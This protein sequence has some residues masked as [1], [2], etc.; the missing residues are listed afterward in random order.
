MNLS[1]V[2]SLFLLVNFYSS[3]ASNSTYYLIPTREGLAVHLMSLNTIYLQ[4]VKS[5]GRVLVLV[6]FTSD[7]YVDSGW[8]NL[9]DYFLFPDN[10]VCTSEHPV[11]VV[12]RMPCVVD[13]SGVWP[14]HKDEHVFLNP[15]FD[16]ELRSTEFPLISKGTYHMDKD[17]CGLYVSEDASRKAEWFPIKPRERYV[18]FYMLIKK[19]FQ[20]LSGA[21]PN[22]VIKYT[23]LHWRRGDQL[24]E[25]CKNG[26]D[27]SINCMNSTNVLS[28]VQ[29]M[30]L[31]DKSITS[32][33]YI[34]TNEGNTTML[35]ELEKAGIY[36]WW[37]LYKNYKFKMKSIEMFIIELQL[38][39]DA[40]RFLRTRA[41]F[42]WMSF[43]SWVDQLIEIERERL[44]KKSEV[45]DYP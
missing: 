14:C 41:N 9:C 1:C 7:H 12:S 26:I 2:T 8:I 39:T 31:M 20:T 5:Y 45:I 35:E 10:I 38:M 6:P 43:A 22:D 27:S 4:V 24:T 32:Y 40:D 3:F 25:R 17:L 29:G 19:I 30:R 37:T 21:G 11:D 15:N 13:C 36:T 18:G 44:G 34:A 33:L 23:V 28:Y 16:L 42:G